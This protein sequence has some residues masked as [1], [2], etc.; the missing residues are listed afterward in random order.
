MFCGFHGFSPLMV[1]T[2]MTSLSQTLQLGQELTILI[3]DCVSPVNFSAQLMQ[4]DNVANFRSLLQD[5]ETAC[6]QE[7]P[8]TRSGPA[9]HCFLASLELN[10]QGPVAQ[11]DLSTSTVIS[12]C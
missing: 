6:T 3:L 10:T 11:S 9:S 2:D 8:H 1:A 7:G 12:Q 4:A 5:V